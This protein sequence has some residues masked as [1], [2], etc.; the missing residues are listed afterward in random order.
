MLNLRSTPT[1][2]PIETKIRNICDFVMYVNDRPEYLFLCG[3]KD[4][5]SIYYFLYRQLFFEGEV[6]DVTY[7]ISKCHL[8]WTLKDLIK[9][10]YG[11]SPYHTFKFYAIKNLEINID[12]TIGDWGED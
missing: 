10:M 6:E 5:E 3:H 8:D 2:I 12:V 11:E 7:H 4:N 1:E 9:S